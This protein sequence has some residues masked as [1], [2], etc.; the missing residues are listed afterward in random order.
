M[1]KYTYVYKAVIQL[2]LLYRLNFDVYSA[3]YCLKHFLGYCN[4]I[5]IAY[6]AK[7]HSPNSLGPFLKW[8]L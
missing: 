1:E 4:Y 8:I 5:G 6:G 3:D 7:F 2:P